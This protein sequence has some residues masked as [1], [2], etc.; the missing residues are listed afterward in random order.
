MRSQRLACI[1]SDTP[2]IQRL[3]HRLLPKSKAASRYG[4]RYRLGG[5]QGSRPTSRP[6][7]GLFWRAPTSRREVDA[8]RTRGVFG[9]VF[10]TGPQWVPC[11]GRNFLHLLGL[12]T[13][14]FAMSSPHRPWR[15]HRAGLV[16]WLAA[17]QV[18]CRCLLD[19][20]TAVTAAYVHSALY[21]VPECHYR[22]PPQIPVLI[23]GTVWPEGFDPV[24]AGVI[25]E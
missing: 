20:A 5:I 15:G 8:V 24:A 4:D 18:P 1:R 14:C 6:R 25:F 22:R 19:E 3:L 17:G 11:P 7:N 2:A 9:C 21:G 10:S 16:G 23:N 13:N 12:T